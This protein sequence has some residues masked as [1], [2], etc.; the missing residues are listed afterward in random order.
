MQRIKAWYKNVKDFWTALLAEDIRNDYV[1]DGRPYHILSEERQFM[2]TSVKGDFRLYRFQTSFCALWREE[3]VCRSDDGTLRWRLEGDWR[4]MAV[5][6]DKTQFA[7][8][9]GKEIGVYN[10]ATG[11]ATSPP[12]ALEL[13]LDYLIW[14][15]GKRLIAAAGQEIFIFD[16]D[17]QLLRKTNM[18]VEDKGFISGICIDP[19]EYHLLTVLD[20]NNQKLL[21]LDLQKEELIKSIDTDF[22]EQLF[23]SDDHRWIWTTVV[24]GT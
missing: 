4:C 9:N 1:D 24:N 2:Q 18:L 20:F 17:A 8:V 6:P 11:N 10:S 3:L 19:S 21:K 16:E 23:G 15:K 22:E 5:S 7:A 12:V 14:T 13:H